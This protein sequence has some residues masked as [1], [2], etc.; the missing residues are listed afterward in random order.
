MEDLVLNRLFFA[1]LAISIII[2]LIFRLY[3]KLL[4]NYHLTIQKSLLLF[5]TKDL[6]F[7][8]SSYAIKQECLRKFFSKKP[9]TLGV[10]SHIAMKNITLAFPLVS[11]Q[12]LT[13]KTSLPILLL[14]AKISLLLNHRERF[15]HIM[16]NLKTPSFI[17]PTA[18]KAQYLYLSSLNEMYLTDM[19]SASSHCSQALRLYQK[20]GYIYE[21]AECY[22]VLMHIYRISGVQDVA[23][24]ML[25]EAEKIYNHLAISAKQ[26][27]VQAYFGLI[28]L[29]RENYDVAMQYLLKAAETA[30]KNNLVNICTS[31]YNWLGLTSFLNNELNKAEQYLKKVLV[32]QQ[33]A[34][35]VAFAAEMLAR[36]YK[37][38]QN[39]KQSLRYTE[40]ALIANR[41]V[42]NSA[43]IFESLYL[44]AEIH[45][46]QKEYATSKNI[47]VE[48]VRH[49]SPPSTIYYPANA[50]TLLGLINMQEGELNMAETYFKQ[51]ADLEHGRNRL[52]GAAIDFNNLAE[53]AR[54]KNLPEDA[55]RYLNQ[56]IEYA[57]KI[58]DEDLKS[59]LLS[60]RI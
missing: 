1:V 43:G 59:Y 12:I 31:I 25:Q 23:F 60:K 48:L 39:Y 13:K 41:Q 36:I 21:E 45:Y 22:M 2:L 27:E 20:L 3:L 52:K 15:S 7:Y 14:D 30:Q 11:H 19:L 6:P 49:K 46:Q 18:I 34:E 44:K 26:S 58:N 32:K 40:Q 28:E 10:L 54:I 33:T 53:L 24:S 16:Q 37:T 4:H 35:N 57:E 9:T 56:A 51:A 8:Y 50:Y 42:Q 47:L 55:E 5:A 17:A 29:G 38:Q